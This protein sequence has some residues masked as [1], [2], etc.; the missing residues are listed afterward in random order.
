MPDDCDWF[1]PRIYKENDTDNWLVFTKDE[2]QEF[3]QEEFQK[4]LKF[5]KVS[6]I[7]CRTKDHETI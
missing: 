1:Y 4:W 7:N 6:P 2:G 3:T 5:R